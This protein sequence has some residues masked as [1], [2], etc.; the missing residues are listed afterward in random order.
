MAISSPGIGSNLDINGIVSKLMSVESQPLTQLTNKEVSYQAK[1]SAYGSLKSALSSFQGSLSSLINPSTFTALSANVGD[2]TVLTA[3][4]SS[5]ASPSSHSVEVQQL[6]QAQSLRTDFTAANVSDVVGTGSLTFYFGTYSG[7]A[8]TPNLTKGAQTVTVDAAHNSL[9]GVRDAINNASIGVSASI[10]NDGTTNR[11]VLTSV[12]GADNSLKIAVSDA[13]GVHD[14]VAS[15]LSKLAYDP[16]GTVG[17]GKNM[18]ET[19]EAKNSIVKVDGV[20][21]NSSTNQVVGAIQGVTLSLAKTN[22]GAAT[23]VSIARNTSSASTSVSNFVKMYNDLA[24]TLKDLTAYDSKTKVAGVLL[25]DSAARSIQWQMRGVLNTA[26]QDLNGNSTTLS[27]IGVSFQKD[28]TLALDSTKLTTAL[29]NDATAVAGLFAALGK[30]E[31]SLIQYVS[32]TSSTLP[33]KHAIDNVVLA[34]QGALAGSAVAGLTI[35]SG[36]NDTLNLTVDGVG[37]AVTLAVGSYTAS[38]LLAEVQSKINGVSAF[39]NAGI[40]VTLS[41]S[42]GIFTMTSNRYGSASNVSIGGNG[43]D[44]LFGVGRT[45][46]AGND[47]SGTINGQAGIGSGQYLTGS[48]GLKIQISGGA[49]GSRGNV[50]FVQGYAFKLNALVSNMLSSTGTISSSTNGVNAAIT[51]LGAKR[52]RLQRHLT[53]VEAQYR[54]QFTRLDTAISKMTA[55]STYLTQQLAAIS[56]LNT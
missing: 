35:S 25:G 43:A 54:A 23:T 41:N 34:T 11:L 21:I 8:F 56:K 42:G 1:L 17:S 51:S 50:N 24:S 47:V 10:V 6:S 19:V 29:N 44:N 48:D 28:G 55:T 26:I 37:T 33:G 3:T 53:D 20:T 39:S 49:P 52:T 46:T 7:G 22:V 12:S 27:S 14:D 32:S 40:A 31:D 4:T 15:G 18:F 2:S 16:A 5:V 38:T 13:D 45:S 36:V 30:P 9:A